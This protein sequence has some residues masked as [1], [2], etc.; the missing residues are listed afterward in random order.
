MNR[1]SSPRKGLI[2]APFEKRSLKNFYLKNRS[3]FLSYLL[4]TRQIS[5]RR[6]HDYLSSLDRKLTDINYLKELK[7]NVEEKY[8]D[9]YGRALKNLFNFMEHQEMEEFNGISPEKWNKAVK[10]K[11][12]GVREIY[13]SNEE[14]REAYQNA[15]KDV[16]PLFKLLAYSGMRLSQ[17]LEGLKNIENAIVK[18][19]IARIPIN[20]ISRGNKRGF[21]I[22][23]P[24]RF[25]K[26]LK[27]FKIKHNYDTY[28]KNLQHKRVSANTIRKWN[29]NFLIEQR[30]PESIAEFIQ[31]R[32]ST[33]VGSAH[34]LN[35]T[36]Q[37]DRE[38]EKI[39]RKLLRIL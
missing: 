5:S 28:S 24:S 4:K 13:V 21:W 17:T 12:P 3:S 23:F 2:K 20:S 22:Y 34:Y 1:G 16:K 18:G 6:A 35:K 7:A 36:I 29:F 27:K 9:S 11:R 15:D 10:L 33:T 8:T 26:E 19:K 30:V 37:A 38:H 25:L 32:A 39:V 14:L 31:G